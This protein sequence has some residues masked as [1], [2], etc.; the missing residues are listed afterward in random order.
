NIDKW[1]MAALRPADYG[2]YVIA[3]VEVPIVSMLA[4]ALGAVLATRL[5]RGFRDGAPDYARDIFVAGAARMSLLVLPIATAIIV[6]APEL[7]GLLF[8]KGYADAALPF[9]VFSLIL[10]HRVAEYGVVLR[11][12]GETRSLWWASVVLVTS[13]AILSLVGVL[14]LGM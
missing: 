6:A 7:L 5:V 10:F 8:T 13:N 11:A 14:T 3:G 4:G 12:A 9:Q 2:T 1:Y